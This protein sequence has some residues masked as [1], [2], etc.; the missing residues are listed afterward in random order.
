MYAMVQPELF[1]T[2]GIEYIVVI[3]FLL[4]LTVAWQLIRAPKV[5]V[6]ESHRERE[7]DWRSL[8]RG[9]ALPGNGVFF[10]PGHSWARMAGSDGE[11]VI[12]WDDFARRLIGPPD[13]IQLPP[14]GTRLSAGGPAW[15]ITAGG[16]ELPMV[17]PVDGEVVQLNDRVIDEPSTASR[18]PYGDGWLMRVR[19]PSIEPVRRN[20]LT[21]SLARSWAEMAERSLQGLAVSA[22]ESALGA[23]LADGGEPRFGLARTLAPEDWEEI[24]R[25]FLLVSPMDVAEDE[26][27]KA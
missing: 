3:S 14:E 2:K 1:G 4:L 9:V 23:V 5:A 10:H 6:S 26:N 16:R 19:V 7:A 8:L 20:L 21:G 11:V 27:V 12:G 22:P 25:S 17:S 15:T 24:V 18:D 13:R